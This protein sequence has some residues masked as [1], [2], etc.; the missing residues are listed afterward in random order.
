M[1]NVVYKSSLIS[2]IPFAM[3]FVL[4]WVFLVSLLVNFLKQGFSLSIIS[5][6]IGI[7]VIGFLCVMFILNIFRGLRKLEIRDNEIFL[8][9]SFSKYTFT[10]DQLQSVK[11][12][13]FGGKVGVYRIYFVSPQDKKFYIPLTGEKGKEVFTI[14]KQKIEQGA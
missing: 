10:F 4:F 9:Y 7:L 12:N 11:M 5:L 2:D 3:M 13:V 14:F 6:S 8:K 1:S